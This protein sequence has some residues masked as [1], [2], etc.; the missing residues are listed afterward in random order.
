MKEY[1]VKVTVR[2][3][4]LLSAIED[5]GYKSQSEFARFAGLT[6]QDVNAL[7]AMR[8]AP[9]NSD[10][11]FAPLAK[12]IMEVLGACPTDL[13]TEEQLT[14]QLRK[15]S[16]EKELSKEALELALSMNCQNLVSFDSVDDNINKEEFTKQLKDVL[17]TL[18][19]RERK[20]LQLRFGLDNT[21]EQTYDAIGSMFELGGQRVRQIEA[22]ALKKM[23]VFARSE[24]LLPYY[25]D[26]K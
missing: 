2:N 8:L 13:W 15:N 26:T 24:K 6:P 23:R 14:M 22:R 11:E 5:A 25:Q 10:G 1:R 19:P 9:I 12:A 18:P 20:V 17:E 7:V 3:N 16:I 21:N 4:L